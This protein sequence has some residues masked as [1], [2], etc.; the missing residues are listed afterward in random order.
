[1]KQ[2]PSM[3]ARSDARRGLELSHLNTQV[4]PLLLLR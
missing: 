1:M 3:L 2:M 4:T